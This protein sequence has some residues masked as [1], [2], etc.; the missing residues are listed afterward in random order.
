M[1]MPKANRVVIYE[2][3]FKGKC[4]NDVDGRWMMGGAGHGVFG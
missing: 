2:H 4:I 3:L 1:L